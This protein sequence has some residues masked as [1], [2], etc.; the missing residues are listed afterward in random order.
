M[1]PDR[2]IDPDINLESEDQMDR[3]ER[4]IASAIAAKVN[5][6]G[7]RESDG[8]M[9]GWIVGV[10]TTLITSFIL[11]AWYQSEEMASLKQEVIDLR[12]QVERLEKL[13]EPRYR[14]AP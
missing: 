5:V 1:R 8:G 7:Y 10:G 2:R 4:L 9:R 12:G 6:S 11:G 14:N 3:L 13:V